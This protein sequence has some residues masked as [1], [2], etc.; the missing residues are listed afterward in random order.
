MSEGTQRRL[1]TIVAADIAGFS[2][3]V[4][5]D[6][7][8]TLA[9]QRGHRAELIEPLLSE[10]HGRIANTAGDSFLF[11]FSSAVEAVRC[12]MAVQEGMAQRN[13][14]V[15]ADQ[16]I[17]YRIG[18]NVGDVVRQSD[19]LLGDGVNVAARLE[20]LAEP[21]GICISR[22]ARDQ[23]RDRME[24]ELAD[25]GEVE[26]KNIARP[27][28]V[29][30]VLGEDEVA[31]ALVR[32]AAPWWKYAAAAV[33]ILAVLV[34]GGVWWWQQ[35]VPVISPADQNKYAY[36]LP[37][38]PSIAVLPF[39][40]LTGDPRQ[41]YIG[42]G[43]SENII[44]VL[45]TSPNLLVIARNSSFT[46][47]GKA[48]K[49]QHVAE[50]LGVRYV[51]EGSVQ[52]SGDKLRVT[53]QLIDA[54]NGKHLWAERYDREL[55]DLFKVQD[56][57]AGRIL[58]EMQVKLTM[59][60]QARAWRTRASDAEV[61]RLSVQGREHLLKQTPEGNAAAQRLYQQ[62]YDRDPDGSLTNFNLGWLYQ[63][64]A[65]FGFG[66][67]AKENLAKAR[68]YAEKAITAEDNGEAR[69][70]LGTMDLF[71]GNFDAA[72]LNADR[73]VELS[74][75]SGITVAVSGWVKIS[76][77][78]V[79]EGLALV[80]RSM[81]L[82][83]YYPEWVG[84]VAAWA[85]LQLG[86]YEQAKAIY[87]SHLALE[88]DNPHTRLFPLSNLAVIA[89]F[90]G[91][92]ESGREYIQKLLEIKPNSSVELIRRRSSYGKDKA[93]LN[94][95]L[96]ALRKAGLPEHP[97]GA[98]PKKPSIAVLPFANLSD[99]KE[100]EYFADGM[101]DDL[102]TDLSKVSGLIVIARNSVFTYKGRNVKVQEVARDLNVS[103]VLEGSVR[104]AG[105]KVR[106]NAQ[107]I[108]ANTGA[109]LWAEKFDRPIGDIFALQDEVA[110][111]IVEAL[112]VT[113]TTS[114]NAKLAI[115]GTSSSKAHDLYLKAQNASNRLNFKKS[116]KEA[117]DLYQQ[118]LTIDPTF[119]DAY[120]GDAKVAQIVWSGSYGSVL[121]G[122]DARQRAEQS[123]ARALQ[124]DPDNVVALR[125][126]A[127]LQS[128]EGQSGDA[129]KTLQE[130]VAAHP[131]DAAAQ[132]QLGYELAIAGKMD[133]AVA[134]IERAHRL[135]PKTNTIEATLMGLIYNFSG[136]HERALPYYKDVER[137]A[138]KS[139]NA[140]MGQ[141]VAYAEL[142]RTA[143][144]E[145]AVETIKRIWPAYN[146]QSQAIFFRHW[147]KPV[148]EQRLNAMRKA[149]VP[150]WPFDFSGKE[151][152][153][154][155]GAEI[156]E[157]MFGRRLRGKARSGYAFET[158]IE[159]DGH[160]TSSSKYFRISGK[161]WVEGDLRCL[162]S[163]D[164][165]MG[166]H[167]C[168]PVYRNSAGSQ[169]TDDEFVY[170][171]IWGVYRFSVVE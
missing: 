90:E 35:R 116:L 69:S 141:V 45:A 67:S 170:A 129:L 136:Q 102:I 142:G 97:P 113:L 25:M 72:T 106:I 50:Q 1:T 60:E 152:D 118:A 158:D 132:R 101:T 146:V 91:N 68:E 19:D 169:A 112:N 119:A 87:T 98:K 56:D 36:E 126:S 95:S 59:G 76:S 130:I 33:V 38:Q 107:L 61:V 57:I 165:I 73:A 108:D 127:W 145:K 27:V 81:R 65:Q 103:H 75:S 96:D 44:A 124:L 149:G 121:K 137:H 163:K 58:E 7:E 26:V 150:E 29:F 16:R 171:T 151:A 12:A 48:T 99:D 109:H 144:A 10:F 89:V 41:D 4:G 52:R 64:K 30:R 134:S 54:L 51:L 79:K 34:G 53:T 155:S 100:Q 17:E 2:R 62:A 117:L 160:W 32:G 166:R 111:E 84:T 138:P 31:G 143:E 86:E 22:T 139:L 13:Q 125:T 47:K 39:D 66:G 135:D 128:Y 162:S 6:E 164:A 167:Y 40:N 20:G 140:Y 154:L 161:S 114:E 18:I 55:N 63:H 70:L 23:V 71:S 11:E 131:N 168:H 24:I 49:V 9:A 122:S 115:R 157:I 147:S 148:L 14:A 43:L 104:R 123:L 74:P 78:Q 21:G 88:K 15:T 46:Y 110:K 153:R 83:P 77:G 42:D 85:H 159:K 37:Q 80:K 105:G 156:K 133:E 82:E 5:N 28:R 93:F 92:V 94:R 120:A 3:L 8:G